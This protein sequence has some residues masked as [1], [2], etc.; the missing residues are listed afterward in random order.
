VVFA[1]VGAL[2]MATTALIARPSSPRAGAR[3]GGRA[4]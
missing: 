3:A 1:L 4:S 2:T